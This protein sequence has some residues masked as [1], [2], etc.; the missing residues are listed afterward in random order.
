MTADTAPVHHE[1]T[2]GGGIQKYKYHGDEVEIH[3]SI[4]P[5]HIGEETWIAVKTP[6]FRP[7]FK[8]MPA[9]TLSPPGKI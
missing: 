6:T 8:W 5:V 4:G 1:P 9:A 3:T 7:G 2:F